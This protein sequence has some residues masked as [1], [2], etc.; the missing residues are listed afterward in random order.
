MVVVYPLPVDDSDYPI[1][2]FAKYEAPHNGNRRG[3]RKREFPVIRRGFSRRGINWIEGG[4]II[5]YS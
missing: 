5:L 3:K 4:R 1:T 2:A